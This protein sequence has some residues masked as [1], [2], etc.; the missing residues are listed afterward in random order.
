MWIA[1]SLFFLRTIVVFSV[2]CLGFVKRSHCSYF[3]LSLLLSSIQ[4]VPHGKL[5]SLGLSFPSVPIA[6]KDF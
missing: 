1:I 2:G 3:F 4:P 6:I 5:L